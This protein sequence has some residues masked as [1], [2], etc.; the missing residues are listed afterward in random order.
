MFWG[1][2]SPGRILYR[3][4][5]NPYRFLLIL[6]VDDVNG[7]KEKRHFNISLRSGFGRFESWFESAKSAGGLMN[8]RIVR[9][10][11]VHGLDGLVGLQI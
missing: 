8:G 5:I 11:L 6:T 10:L 1:T 2:V 7:G 4:Q 3:I 9:W